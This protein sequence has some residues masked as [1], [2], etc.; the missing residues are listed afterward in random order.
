MSASILIPGMGSNAEAKSLSKARAGGNANAAING[1]ESWMAELSS[2]L[3]RTAANNSFANSS[4]QE[5]Q[6][7]L[8]S[9]EL[10]RDRSSAN[11][12]EAQASLQAHGH[13]PHLRA[14]ASAH[15]AHGSHGSHATQSVAGAESHTGN[16]AVAPYATHILGQ[17]SGAHQTIAAPHHGIAT[18]AGA[19]HGVAA[20]TH[21]ALTHQGT[22][23]ST[24]TGIAFPQ[25]VQPALHAGGAS[26]DIPSTVAQPS[27]PAEA[28]VALLRSVQAS[29]D[30]RDASLR[31]VRAGDALNTDVQ[32]ASMATRR[33][34]MD[35][36]QE[37]SGPGMASVNAELGM[38]SDMSMSNGLPVY[39]VQ[40]GSDFLVSDALI[41]RPVEAAGDLAG[42]FNLTD[43]LPGAADAVAGAD[44]ANA[45][46]ADMD[47]M[48]VMEQQAGLSRLKETDSL[49]LD[50]QLQDSQRVALEASL[51]D[52]VLTV[53]LGARADGSFWVPTEQLEALKNSL[54]LATPEVQEVVFEQSADFG[55]AES[56]R[57]ANDASDTRSGESQKRDNPGERGERAAQGQSDRDG[58]R[59]QGVAGSVSVDESR[60]LQAGIGG[61]SLKA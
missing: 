16:T 30:I 6:E 8:L 23:H 36:L 40:E 28:L 57:G 59:G 42:F 29:G 24:A 31:S 27:S 48:A 51:Q 32:D 41:E 26:T 55:S 9:Q 43:R 60:S 52:G 25:G 22:V 46:N 11:S 19:L 15:A 50:L 39:S 13:A 4:A 20:E 33:K 54:R 1:M 53:K 35:A 49:R 17:D 14:D 45:L 58:I 10:N 47:W 56:D 61:I 12:T 44:A 5:R 21:H 7:S 3:N 34:L 18:T 38:A 2:A 37:M